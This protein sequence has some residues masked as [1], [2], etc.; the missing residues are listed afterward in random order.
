M[1]CLKTGDCLGQALK[2]VMD[3]LV[4]TLSSGSNHRDAIMIWSKPRL[5][6]T[7]ATSFSSV[8]AMVRR[9]CGFLHRWLCSVGPLRVVCYG[10]I[11]S[12]SAAILDF[13]RCTVDEK[14]LSDV[15]LELLLRAFE[16][17]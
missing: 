3:I 5:P 7:V 13:I 10:L 8:T 16:H 12:V 4:D 14:E 9:S 1:S 17:A 2:E 15:P 11:V 6:R